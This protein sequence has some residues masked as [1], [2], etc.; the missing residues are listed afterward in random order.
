MIVNHADRLHVRVNNRWADK[1][2]ASILQVL[3]EQ[4]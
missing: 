3:A 2:K 1:I 4:L